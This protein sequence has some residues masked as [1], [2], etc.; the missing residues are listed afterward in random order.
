MG[1]GWLEFVFL[2]GET[3]LP[4]SG[5]CS[6]AEEAVKID[7]FPRVDKTAAKRQPQTATQRSG[8][9]LEAKKFPARLRSLAVRRGFVPNRGFLSWCGH[10]D[11]NPN[12][13][14]HE[15]LNLACLPIPSCPHRYVAG[16]PCRYFV[17]KKPSPEAAAPK[18][19]VPAN[20]ITGT[21]IHISSCAAIRP[22]A[23]RTGSVY[24]TV[25]S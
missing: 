25:P 9:G 11:S 2:H 7:S 12:A 13:S 5:L 19:R 14:L 15:N 21:S 23:G 18:S 22:P 17:I 8:C 10:G 24:H 20:S 16:T 6:D 1:K 3:C 4:Q